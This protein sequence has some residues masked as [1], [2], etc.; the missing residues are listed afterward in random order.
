M[1]A[2]RYMICI[3]LLIMVTTVVGAESD[4]TCL[5]TWTTQTGQTVD[6]AFEKLQYNKVYL[7]KENGEVIKISKSKLAEKD[8]KLISE[9][10]AA[11]SPKKTSTKEDTQ[12][13]DEKAAK[14]LYKLFGSKFK[15]AKKSSLSTDELAGKTIGVYFSAH[16]CPPCRA[17]TPNLVKFYNLLKKADK[18]FEI[19][20]VSSD[21]DKK[22]M[23]KYMKEMKMPWLALPYGDK[24]KASLSSTFNVRGIPK[25]VILN[26]SGELI[27][28]NGTGDVMS[29][30]D[31]SVFDKWNP[32]K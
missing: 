9:L 31:I 26:A 23:Y 2:T 5:R 16:W 18:P 22:A 25:L 32:T 17:F 21:R 7:K 10:T 8:Q 11:V 30:D 19:V 29:G 3:V 14:A 24:H 15:N 12:A 6:A 4:K 27:T 20:F 13:G 28:E 1:N